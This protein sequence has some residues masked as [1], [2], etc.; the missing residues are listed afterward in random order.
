MVP[1]K[2]R[3]G[4]LLDVGAAT[5]ILM[6]VAQEQGYES[7]GVE[8]ASDGVETI[9]QKF[10][11]ERVFSGCFDQI[12]FT[13]AGM[14]GKF[15]IVT[16]IDTLEHV[17]DPNE[18]LRKV[19][20][21]LKPKGYLLLYFPNTASWTARILGKRWNYYCPEHLFSFSQDCISQ[22]LLKHSFKVC[23]LEAAPKYLTIEYFNNVLERIP[24]SIGFL[25]SFLAHSPSALKRIPIPLYVGQMKILA[26]KE[27]G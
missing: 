25:R 21:L 20:S 18:A 5:G 9:K 14:M 15:D 16:M 26:Q 10:G 23:R 7:Y 13:A 2:S 4:K 1:E 27:E 12:D 8:V 19:Y 6:E 22:I 11:A 3:G 24:G 17:R